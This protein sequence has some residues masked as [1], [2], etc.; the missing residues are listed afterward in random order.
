MDRILSRDERLK[1][2]GQY[3][4]EAATNDFGGTALIG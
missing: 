2:T 4:L 3:L 1:P